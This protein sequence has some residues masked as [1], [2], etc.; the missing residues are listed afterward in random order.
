M[1]EIHIP[2]A[3]EV[4]NLVTASKL[5]SIHATVMDMMGES[6]AATMAEYRGTIRE[7]MRSHKLNPI[8]VAAFYGKKL[9]DEGNNPMPFIAACVQFCYDFPELAKPGNAI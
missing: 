6:F 5:D 8:E 9:H 1:S 7:L 2:N 3:A 4:A